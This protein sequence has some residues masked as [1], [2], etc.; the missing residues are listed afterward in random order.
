MIASAIVADDTVRH[1]AT[2]EI[3][4]RYFQSQCAFIIGKAGAEETERI[5][6]LMRNYAIKETDRPTV[7]AAR[8]AISGTAANGKGFQGI[9]CGAAIELRDGSIIT[10]RNSSTLRAASSAILNALKRLAGIPDWIHLL[11]E[12]VVQ[13]VTAMKS[14]NLNLTSS[15]LNVEE[16]LIALAIAGLHNNATKHALE[17][18]SNLKGCD[19]HMTH[20]TTDSDKSGL[21]RLGICLTT[22]PLYPTKELFVQ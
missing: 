16:L 5:T 19:M 22:D 6:N 14:Q 17:M 2:Q 8:D 15:N 21:R 3:I 12:N 10:G 13:S 18:I 11:P 9:C 1:A 7:Q 4:R 20:I